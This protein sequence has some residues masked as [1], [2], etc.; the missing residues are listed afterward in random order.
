MSENEPSVP[1]SKLRTIGLRNASHNGMARGRRIPDHTIRI[2]IANNNT[3]PMI[4]RFSSKP[5]CS[6]I[7]SIGDDELTAPVMIADRIDIHV[8]P[9]SHLQNSQGPPWILEAEGHFPV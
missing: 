7:A 5:P 8:I 4:H 6:T 2:E 9:W 3:T 1:I